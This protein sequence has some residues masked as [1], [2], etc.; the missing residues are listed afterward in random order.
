VHIAARVADAARAGEVC[1]SR[2]VTDLVAGT[3]LRF[4][5]RGEHSLRDIEEPWHLFAA[6][7]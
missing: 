1:V 6:I 5:P 2:T 3:G 7:L 4:D